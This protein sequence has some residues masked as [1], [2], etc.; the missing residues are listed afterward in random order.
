ME[1][2]F[3]DLRKKSREILRALDQNERVTVLYRG[4]PKAVL[5]PIRTR[6]ART[7]ARAGEHAAF[8]MWS[9]RDDLADVASYV[10]RI[11]QG[12]GHAR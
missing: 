11:R 12:R 4:K 2:S 8:G 6:S 5:V 1:A 9:D 7:S 10:R 3:V